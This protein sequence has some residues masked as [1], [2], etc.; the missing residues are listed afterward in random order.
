MP[1]KKKEILE[2]PKTPSELA[3]PTAEAV[4]AARAKRKDRSEQSNMA[5]CQVLGL[6]EGW[7]AAILDPGLPDGQIAAIGER[8]TAKGWIR[9]DGLQTVTGYPNGAY[10]FVKTEEDYQAA[11]RERAAKIEAA[12]KAG[13]MH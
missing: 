6:P 11:I 8:W 7:R 5:P 2:Q 12:R 1:A 3:L 10:V 4:A 9:L 13:M